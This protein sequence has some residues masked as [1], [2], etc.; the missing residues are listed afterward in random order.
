M[1]DSERAEVE[2]DQQV[3]DARVKHLRWLLS[4]KLPAKADQEPLL[5]ID[6]E[7]F[8]LSWEEVQAI[9]GQLIF[10]KFWA[11]PVSA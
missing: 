8:R 7:I 4:E 9:D 5:I 6:G 1:P 11:E 2:W 10:T 3:E